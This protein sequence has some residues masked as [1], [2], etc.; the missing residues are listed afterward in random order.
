MYC[1]LRELYCRICIAGG[2][3][4]GSLYHNTKNCIVRNS[5]KRQGCLCRKTGSCVATRR[6]ARQ[7]ARAQGRVGH[8]GRRRGVGLGVRGAL[9]RA[10]GRQ[11]QAGGRR[12]G[13]GLS[14]RAAAGARGLGAGRSAWA[15]GLALG[16]ALGALGLFLARFDSVFS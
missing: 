14:E 11:A 2:L 12:S 4:A 8:A 1:S 3:A 13:T 5:G 15:R 16:C 6:W 7:Q 9:G 10:R